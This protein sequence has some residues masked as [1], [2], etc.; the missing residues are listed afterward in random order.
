MCG[1]FTAAVEPELLAERFGVAFP[2]DRPPR[3]NVAPTQEVAAIL[4]AREGD[5]RELR[6][7]RWGL[8]PHYAADASGAARMINARSETVRERPAFKGLLQRRR[9]LVCADGFYEWR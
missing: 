2:A 8:V 6:W 7:L 5:G 4:S 1:R 9:C 3:Y